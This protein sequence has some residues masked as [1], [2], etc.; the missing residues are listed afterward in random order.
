MIFSL[1]YSE[2]D[3]FLC[4]L[5][6]VLVYYFSMVGAVWFVILAYSWSICF[7]SLGSTRDNFA[8]KVIYFHAIA[9]ILPLTW[10]ISVLALQQVRV[11][12]FFT[13]R[14]VKPKI[15]SQIFKL[16]FDNNLLPKKLI[17]QVDA[18]SLS[19]ICFVGYKKP[20]MRAGFLLAPL[21]LDLIV[22]GVFLTQGKV[23]MAYSIL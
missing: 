23:L 5:T 20:K 22:G 16:D 21:S 17:F 19:G 8:G 11:T 9:W 15:H 10:T 2:D 1:P 18:N 7:K 13:F 3:C 6:F 4:I 12:L 14:K